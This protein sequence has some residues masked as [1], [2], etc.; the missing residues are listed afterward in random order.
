MKYELNE[1]P[2]VVQ[3][4]AGIHPEIVVIIA[5]VTAP[6]YSTVFCPLRFDVKALLTHC[7]A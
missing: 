4:N 3:T 1:E 6:T 2:V 7:I 5:E